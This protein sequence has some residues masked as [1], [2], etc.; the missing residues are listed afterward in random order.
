[1][2]I[3]ASSEQVGS[4]IRVWLAWTKQPAKLRGQ[5]AFAIRPFSCEPLLHAAHRRG[6][7]EVLMLIAV[8]AFFLPVALVAAA[9]GTFSHPAGLRVARN[10]LERLLRLSYHNTDPSFPLLRDYP[11][12][13]VIVFTGLTCYLFYRNCHLM[14]SLFIHIHESGLIRLDRSTRTLVRQELAKANSLFVAAGRLSLVF[15]F[16]SLGIAALLF[17]SSHSPP[18]F[19]PLAPGATQHIRA[20]WGLA[21]YHLWWATMDRE[22]IAG[23]ITYMFGSAF[24]VYI[25]LKHNIAGICFVSFFWAVRKHAVFTMD[26]RNADGYYGWYPMRRLVLSVFISVAASLIAFTSLFT[27]LPFHAI[28]GYLPFALIYLIGIPIYVVL[29]LWLLG[30]AADR[31][32]RNEIAI[33]VERFMRVRRRTSLSYSEMVELERTERAEIKYI[34]DIRPRLFRMREVSL[35]IILYAVPTATSLLSVIHG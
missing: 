2:R 24:T 32:R 30:R 7:P 9:Q 34:R 28:S 26:K 15:A 21:A 17:V 29:P 8:P 20:R 33:T 3:K 14:E 25:I 27:L 23:A 31:F 6:V 16:V 1:M 35:G 4:R 18:I 5:D 10:D 11:T 19:L 22:H 13:I 12:L